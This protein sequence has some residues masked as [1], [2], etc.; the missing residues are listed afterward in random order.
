MIADMDTLDTTYRLQ[1]SDG[2]G[3]WYDH[4]QEEYTSADDIH[5]LASEMYGGLK[6]DEYR[7][8]EITRRVIENR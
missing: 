6:P 7:L 3:D 8:I 5:R 4:S 2:D 1:I